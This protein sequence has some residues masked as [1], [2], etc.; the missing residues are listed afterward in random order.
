M[1]E[2]DHKIHALH[3]YYCW[4]TLLK[5][6]F[7]VALSRGDWLPK[8][9]ES[10]LILPWKYMS[11]D[12]GMYMAYWYASLFVVCEGWLELGLSDPE[13]ERLLAEPN[14]DLLKRY[15][16]GTF[17]YQ[18]K[19]FDERFTDFQKEQGSVIWVR[20]LSQALGAWFLAYLRSFRDNADEPKKA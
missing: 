12:V 9:A 11:S 10:P 18:K 4:T 8:G 17:H 5:R 20:E 16:N 2:I 15:R 13:V 7:E 14:L 6:D 19:Y 3:R 1:K